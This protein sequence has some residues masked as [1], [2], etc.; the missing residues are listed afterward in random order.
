MP[1][2]GPGKSRGGETKKVRLIILSFL[3]NNCLCRMWRH[4]CEWVLCRELVDIGLEVLGDTFTEEQY[5]YIVQ[6]YLQLT[7]FQM[8]E[9]LKHR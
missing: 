4:Q 3:E 8:D 9:R 1:L 6:A 5:P 2:K 7:N